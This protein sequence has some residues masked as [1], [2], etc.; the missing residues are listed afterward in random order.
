MLWYGPIPPGGGSVRDNLLPRRVQP[1]GSRHTHAFSARTV[2][3]SRIRPLALSQQPRRAPRRVVSRF[4]PCRPTPCPPARTPTTSRPRPTAASGTR[5]RASGRSAAS[6]RRPARSARSGLGDGLRAAR[7]DRRAG[8]RAVDHRRRPERDRARRPGDGRRSRSSRCPARRPDANLNT[9][10]FDGDGVLWFTG[11][12]GIYGRLDPATG[13]IEVFDAPRGR[14]PYGI[15]ATPDGEVWYAS[16]A[17][18]YLGA[19]RP[20]DRRGRRSSTR[21]RPARARA[22]SGPTPSGRLWVSEWNAGQVGRLRPGRPARGASGRSP[23][24]APQAYAVY[25]DDAR[26]R[27]ADRLRRQRDRPLRPRR[28]SSSL[29]SRCRAP[30]P[31]CASCSAAR[32]RCGAPSRPPTSWSS[33]GATSRRPRAGSR[34]SRSSSGRRRPR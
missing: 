20:G 7:R 33:S 26:H 22:A 30:T 32:A 6:T 28:P 31:R 21:R 9:A 15:A 23:A 1:G 16:L 17:G 5:A 12:A 18:S 25:V 14:G 3:D 19:D 24:T 2:A 4:S 11:Q 34:R 10:A 13:A 29:S 27:L 8:R